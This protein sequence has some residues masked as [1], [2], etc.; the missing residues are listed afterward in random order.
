[1][2]PERQL[3]YLFFSFLFFIICLHHGI[4][5]AAAATPQ[6][7]REAPEFYNSPECPSIEN[8]HNLICS[9]EAVHAAMTLDSAYIRGSM[10]AILSILQHSS[11]PQNIIFH[12]VASASMTRPH[13][14]P[15]FASFPYLK[16]E[17]YRFDDS[18]VS[19]LISTSIRS[20]LDCPLN[21]A[22]SY[23][24]NILPLCVRKVVYLDSDLV[25]V[26][27]IAKLAAT[28]LIDQHGLGDNFRGLCQDLH[29]GQ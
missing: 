21:Y 25:L 15:P 20:A 6:Q 28:P 14:L 19:G 18:S 8:T 5:N 17:V 23:L 3:P 13:T 26:D 9:D 22:R 12:F 7:F 11:C 29:P 24:A 16:F 10:A 27:D 4:I 1:M 2:K